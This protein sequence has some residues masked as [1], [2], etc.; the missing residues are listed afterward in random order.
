[1]RHVLPLLLLTAACGVDLAPSFEMVLQESDAGTTP[2]TGGLPCAVSDMVTQHC[3]RC[4]G[5]T[6]AEGAPYRLLTIDDFKANSP[7]YPSQ[8]VGGRALVRLKDTV[9]P[10]PPVPDT[11]A[12]ADQI[13]QFE[14]WFSA[15]MPQGTCGAVDGGPDLGLPD[16]GTG[17]F[18]TVCTSNRKWTFGNAGSSTMNPGY[19]CRSCH[20]GQDFMSQN[21]THISQPSRAYDF[22][23]TVFPTSH[24]QDLCTDSPPGA[25]TVEIIDANGNVAQRLGVNS[26]GNFYSGTGTGVQKPYTA[27]VL[28]SG[29]TRA[30]TTPQTDGD[31]NTCHTEQGLNGAPGRIVWPG[32]SL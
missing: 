30:M 16:A 5:T 14:A 15:G 24:E 28:Y 26:A 29:R 13:S 22:M 3:V 23:G 18:P 19:A 27:R 7:L 25:V 21:P 31:C 11:A 6:L 2:Q 20:L 10:M 4:H 1:M 8:T 12:P 32:P 9:S 17:P